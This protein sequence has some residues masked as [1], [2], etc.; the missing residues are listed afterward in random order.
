MNKRSP[1][2]KDVLRSLAAGLALGSLLAAFSAPPFFQAFLGAFVLSALC[3]FALLRTWRGFG[4]EKPLVAILLIAFL[5]RLVSGVVIY[6]ILPTAGYADSAVQKAGYLYSDAWE[7]DTAAIQLVQSG[8]SIFSPFIKQLKS[9]QYGGLLTVT[10]L[11]Y[12]LFSPDA[13]RPLLITL[14]ASFTMTVGLVFLWSCLK[15]LFGE[16]FAR[17]AVWTA[18]LYP[19]GILLS[20]SQMREPF[21]I[22]LGCIAFWAITQWEQH[23]LKAFLVFFASIVGLALFSVPAA[24]VIGGTCLAL[25]L[26]QFTLN[27][28]T[29]MNRWTGIEVLTLLGFIAIISGWMWLQPTLYYEVYQAKMGSGMLQDLFQLIPARLTVPFITVYGLLQPVLPAA[30]TEPS[31]P[32]WTVLGIIRAAGWYFMLP[33]LLYAFFAIVKSRKE[34]NGYVLLLVGVI[35]FVWTVVSSARAA[36]DQWDN[37]RYR[38]ILLPWMSMVFAWTWLRIREHHPAWFWRWVAVVVVLTLGFS[39]WY[40]SRKWGLGIWMDF[41]TVVKVIAG[42]SALILLGGAVYDGIKNRRTNRLREAPHG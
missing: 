36:G 1:L 4:S 25:V 12:T 41:F 23:H 34:K 26:L 6:A 5:L 7:R 11:I 40:V 37:P 13:A 16:H 39:N 10:A 24:M 21:L 17:I 30:I 32:F 33:F 22:G 38:A 29:T 20:S 28:E 19:E 3:C 2:L 9:D 18:A 15:E 42:I 8:D 14:L 35:F 27:A 31:L